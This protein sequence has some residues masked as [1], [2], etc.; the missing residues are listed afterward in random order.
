[1]GKRSER[2]YEI[3]GNIVDI[4]SDV[5]KYAFYAAL[6]FGVIFVADKAIDKVQIWWSD[7]KDQAALEASVLNSVSIRNLSWQKSP[8]SLLES[9]EEVLI[10]SFTV[11][12]ESQYRIKDFGI[13]LIV[14]ARSGTELQTKHKTI[15]DFVE[16]ES[17]KVFRNIN[18]GSVH[19]QAGKVEC[20]ITGLKFE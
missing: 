16:P 19:D 5:F 3:V 6:L 7:I 4:V 18:V 8:E 10:I 14:S 2:I 15:Y 20:E 1:M 9:R 11:K 13:R 17:K 12:N